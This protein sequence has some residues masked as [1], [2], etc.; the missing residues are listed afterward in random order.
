[1]PGGAQNGLEPDRFAALWAG[2][3][4]GNGNEAEAVN[5]FRALRRMAVR[6]NVRIVDLMG[7]ADVM[8]A[9]DTQLQPVREESPELREAFGKVT[10][11]A[12][13][14]ARERE[15]TSQLRERLRGG[16]A[17]AAGAG[18]AVPP[19]RVADT[20]LVHG[21]LVAA[22]SIATVVLMIAAAFEWLFQ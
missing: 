16:N 3:D 19:R 14:L 8:A 22:V 18:K 17:P 15:I 11:L 6:D 2:C 12:D 1:M 5:K 9:L 13:A 10:Q 7:R 20:G 21:A 4:T